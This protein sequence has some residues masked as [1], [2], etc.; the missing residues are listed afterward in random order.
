MMYPKILSVKTISET[1]LLVEFDNAA[2]R[3][4]DIKPLLE[5]PMFYPLKKMAFFRNVQVDDGGYAIFWNKDIDLSEYEL[6]MHGKP[7]ENNDYE[8]TNN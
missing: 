3:I 6:W 5:K 1:L 7:I 2:K 8:P 4:Y